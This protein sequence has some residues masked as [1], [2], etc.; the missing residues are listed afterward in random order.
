MRVQTFVL[1]ALALGASCIYLFVSAPPPLDDIE[2]S[3][4]NSLPVQRMFDVLAAENDSART[5][6]TSQV[7]GPGI[8]A[9]LKFN[10]HWKDEGVEA[11]PLPALFLREVSSRLAKGR[12]E[13]GLFLGSDFPISSVNRF[14]GDQMNLFSKVKETKRPQYA[15]DS[16]TN[17]HL[18]MYPDF[19]TAAPC[20][21]CHN[22]HPDSPKT[23]WALND[24]MGATTWLYPQPQVSVETSVMAVAAFRAAVRATYEDYLA[25]TRT[26]STNRPDIGEKWPADGLF[27][28]T[29]DV[30]MKA[31][32]DRASAATLTRILDLPQEG[33]DGAN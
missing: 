4:N 6:Y 12:T 14:S 17:M 11:G 1:A 30:F 8:K 10:E 13:I 23:D 24:M 32:S 9:G 28:P 29:A 31:V 7:V 22:A 5:L 27:L 3:A 20:V 25:K 33:T 18:A 26:F 15:E 2:E 16:A 19:A 21:S